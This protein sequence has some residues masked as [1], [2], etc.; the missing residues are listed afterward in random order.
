MSSRLPDVWLDE[1]RGRV[2]IVDV[3]SDYVELKQKGR[4]FWGRCPFH[5][6]KTPSFS[7]DSEAQMY[8][9]FGCHKG[10]TV[11]NFVMDIE[12]MEFMDAVRMLAERA[13]ME[14]PERV[15]DGRDSDKMRALRERIDEANLEAARFYH[16]TIWTAD[17]AKAL[18]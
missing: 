12:R 3:V 16:A 6:E 7:V 2:D 8:Y 15:G 18:R 5:G 1:L 9:C 17:G 11:I 4:R 13:H 14:L 10:G